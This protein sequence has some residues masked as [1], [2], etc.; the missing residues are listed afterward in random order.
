MFFV[1]ESL[2]YCTAAVIVITLCIISIRRAGPTSGGAWIW[3]NAAAAN[4]P[5]F[6]RRLG[7]LVGV[8]MFVGG[9]DP[10]S[11][12][13]ILIIPLPILIYDAMGTLLQTIISIWLYY[14]TRPLFTHFRKHSSVG[15]NSTSVTGDAGG[16]SSANAEYPNALK[17]VLTILP[18]YNL[19][20]NWSFD[21]TAGVTGRAYW[22]SWELVAYDITLALYIIISLTMYGLL[23]SAL[24]RFI[25]TVERVPPP[26]AQPAR[27]AQLIAPTPT[28]GPAIVSPKPAGGGVVGAG[29]GGSTT[30]NSPHGS[31]GA[32]GG[33]GVTITITSAQPVQPPPPVNRFGIDTRQLHSALRTLSITV[34]IGTV[35]TLIVFGFSLITAVPALT[36]G[37]YDDTPLPD[38]ESEEAVVTAASSLVPTILLSGVFIWLVWIPPPQSRDT[39]KSIAPVTPVVGTGGNKL[40]P[41]SPV[42]ATAPAGRDP[43]MAGG[44]TDAAGGVAY[45][46]LPGSV[47]TDGAGAE[48][49]G[50]GVGAVS[51]VTGTA[52]ALSSTNASAVQVAATGGG[53]MF[54]P[55]RL[56]VQHPIHTGAT[57]AIVRGADES[58]AHPTSPINAGSVLRS[59]IRSAAPHPSVLTVPRA[60]ENV[61]R[62]APAA[63]LPSLIGSA[64]VATDPTSYAAIQSIAPIN[65]SID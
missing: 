11:A 8:L 6:A 7:V 28:H 19:S 25:E 57:D 12:H 62:T 38:V 5:W 49:R 33:G 45:V 51:Q 14:F 10:H 31:S 41:K 22:S 63:P 1:I 61:S 36:N 65:Q 64:P 58:V 43:G 39:V 42:N 59:D 40:K 20:A 29:T 32:G 34:G 46:V 53:P 44:A 26:P 54:V 21:I 55:F 48:V 60:A 15:I 16:S 23:R 4:F 18:I 47:D 9:I 37:P 24:T 56:A 52:T 35:V 2:F 27:P 50:A 30:A 3:P 17:A 13:G